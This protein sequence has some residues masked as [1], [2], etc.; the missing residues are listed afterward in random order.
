[1]IGGVYF[2]GEIPLGWQVGAPPSAAALHEWMHADAVLLNALAGMESQLS[3]HETEFGGDM[4]KRLDRLE[5]K[6]DLALNLLSNLL[7]QNTPKPET[8]PVTLSASTIEWVSR[9]A[10]P[11]KGSIVISLFIDPRMPQ[12]L[13]LPASVRE[14]DAATGGTRIVADF[15][16]LSEEVKDSLERAVFRHH[17]RHIQA[18][19]GANKHQG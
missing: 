3:A 9:S 1:M 12:P 19:H 13:M 2:Q 6:L 17:R 15:T 11:A 16:H 8:C 5:A 7:A 4:E 14:S 10:A 18:M